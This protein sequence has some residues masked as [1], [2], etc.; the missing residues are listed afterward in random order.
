[1]SP[2]PS[3]SRSATSLA[4]RGKAS[5]ESGTES[6]SSSTSVTSHSPSLSVSNGTE[7]ASTG[8]V[9]HATSASSLHPSPSSSSSA[10]SPIPSPSR[11]EISLPS[12]GKL[13]VLSPTPSP[14]E[15]VVSE[16]SIGKASELSPI[17]SP[18]VSAHS[19]GFRWNTSTSSL[20]PSPSESRLNPS[21]AHSRVSSAKDPSL[22]TGVWPPFS[23][24]QRATLFPSSQLRCSSIVVSSPLTNA[25]RS[26]VPSSVVE[27]SQP[28]RSAQN[29]VDRVA[30]GYWFNPPHDQIMPPLYNITLSRVPWTFRMLG[31]PVSWQSFAKSL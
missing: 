4:S 15:S 21:S 23:M 9:R 2:A 17:P 30:D 26:R 3:P 22:N 12:F 28:E 31:R 6:P 29:D 14:S 19:L 5:L 20:C 8:S 11:S 1:M 18:S 24:L 10:L 25:S 16:L 7:A 13:S 27:P